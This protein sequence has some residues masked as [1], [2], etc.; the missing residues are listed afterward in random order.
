MSSMFVLNKRKPSLEQLHKLTAENAQLIRIIN[1]YGAG[2]KGNPEQVLALQERL[3]RNLMFL[4]EAAK[5]QHWATSSQGAAEPK[6]PPEW[7]FVTVLKNMITTCFWNLIISFVMLF[8]NCLKMISYSSRFICIENTKARWKKST[9]EIQLENVVEFIFWEILS[10]HSVV[11]FMHCIFH[12]IT[13]KSRKFFWS[14]ETLNLRKT[15][16]EFFQF[17]EKR[18]NWATFAL[19][20]LAWKSQFWE[21]QWLKFFVSEETWL[22]S[23]RTLAFYNINRSNN[24]LRKEMIPSVCRFFFSEREPILS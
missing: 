15:G 13:I 7:D 17:Y 6:G 14:I 12:L 19:S 4:A 16:I 22:K 8:R 5:P 21:A 2:G 10:I 9:D 20:P 23:A 11:F 1:E 18:H 3:H 24:I